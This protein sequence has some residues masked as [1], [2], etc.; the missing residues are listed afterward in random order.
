MI[1]SLLADTAQSKP[2]WD[3]YRSVQETPIQ[4]AITSLRHTSIHN[5]EARSALRVYGN[6]EDA[7]ELRGYAYAGGGRAVERVDVSVDGGHSWRQAELLPDDRA[8]GNQSWS[9][10]LWS[11]TIPTH[12]VGLEICCKAT[13]ESYNVQPEKHGPIWNVKVRFVGYP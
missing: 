11:I 8:L 12:L 7:I 5:D 13:D 4:S 6:E 9:W 2:E 1:A 3:R 10:R